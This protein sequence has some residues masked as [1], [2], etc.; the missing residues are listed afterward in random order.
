M[1]PFEQQQGAG[2]SDKT[3]PDSMLTLGQIRHMTL[4]D[5]E[6]CDLLVLENLRERAK[7]AIKQA[8]SINAQELLFNVQLAKSWIECAI[9]LKKMKESS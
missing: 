1:V 9:R 8:R 3:K 2:M 4:K 5:L 7:T 6:S